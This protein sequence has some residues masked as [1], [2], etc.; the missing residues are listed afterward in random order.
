MWTSDEEE[1]IMGLFAGTERAVVV[2]A[3][4]QPHTDALKHK[5]IIKQQTSDYVSQA[6]NHTVF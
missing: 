1:R 4:L 2:L 6:A 5:K 3:G